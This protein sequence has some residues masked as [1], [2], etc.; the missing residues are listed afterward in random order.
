MLGVRDA[1]CSQCEFQDG[2]YNQSF[3]HFANRAGQT[4]WTV[5]LGA[6]PFTLF[7]Y[8]GHSRV[9]AGTGEQSSVDGRAEQ[10]VQMWCKFPGALF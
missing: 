8:R 10:V 9:S 6:V 4:V 2:V 5:V 3:Q 1:A 7:E